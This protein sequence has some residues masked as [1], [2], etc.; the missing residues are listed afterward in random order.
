MQKITVLGNLGRDP[1][2]RSTAN[3]KRIISFPIAV[4]VTKDITQWYDCNIWEEKIDLFKGMLPY[5]K[6]G[7]LILI[8][9]DLGP[10][11]TYLGKDG[12]PKVR[13]RI[14]PLSMN[15]VGTAQDKLPPAPIQTIA[16]M[17]NNANE[18]I[19]F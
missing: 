14:L 6:K 9:G 8:V 12:S 15:F 10:L 11:E 7:S 19:P 16:Q 17:E 1:E 13:A 2:D 4:K 18:E 3:G 5:L